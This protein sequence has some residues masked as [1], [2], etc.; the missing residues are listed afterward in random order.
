MVVEAALAVPQR[1]TFFVP[2][3]IGYERIVESYE[4]ELSGGEKTKEDAAGLLKSSE[5]LRHRYGRI[6]LQMGEILTLDDIVADLRIARD[7]HLTPAKR[8]AVVTRLGNRVMDEINRVTAVTPGALTA[9]ALLTHNKRGVSHEELVDRCRKMLAVLSDMQARVTPTTRTPSGALRPEAIRE[10]AQMF[11][12]AEMLEAHAPEGFSSEAGPQPRGRQ[13]GAPPAGE[14]ILYTV[15]E[16]RR[17]L[18]DTS[19]NIIIHFFVERAL[20]AIAMRVAP[21]P[22]VVADVVRDR[23]QKLSRLL[24][25]EFRFRADAPFD[26]IFDETVEAMVE[27]GV[28]ARDAEQLSPG[29]GNDGWRGGQWLELYASMLQNF[30]EGYRVA[31]RG[32]GGLL[33][34]PLA[35]KDLVKKALATG[36]RMFYAGEVERREALSKPLV[37]NAF[38]AFVDQGYLSQAS[39]KLELSESFRSVKAASAIEGRIAGYLTEALR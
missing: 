39:G 22:P 31:A 6:N 37:E 36:N 8:R 9:M 21:G 10:A 1:K 33:K 26:V 4:R 12:D 29:P 5:V 24:K 17:L 16:S 19:K 20:V 15:V 2:V 27:G 18:L 25:F 14:G 23:V 30:L 13:R 35:E 34:G 32:L 3:S 28:V 11:I 38:R 7:V